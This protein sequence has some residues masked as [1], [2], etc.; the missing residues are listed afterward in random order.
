MPRARSTILDSWRRRSYSLHVNAWG[1]CIG[2]I[3][4]FAMLQHF[5]YPGSL[6]NA[7]V[8][9]VLGP[10]DEIWSVAYGVG[11]LCMF[12]G[13]WKPNRVAD[14]VGLALFA[15]ATFVNA[16]SIWLLVGFQ[17]QV[18]PYLLGILVAATLRFRVITGRVKPRAQDIL[19]IGGDQ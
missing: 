7:S 5:L 13:I 9:D 1:W 16:I 15:G 4:F 12:Y 14:A 11:G 2:L 3:A 18:I 10:W 6:D 19:P 17:P 8:N